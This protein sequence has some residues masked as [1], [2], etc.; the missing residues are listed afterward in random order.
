MS[1]IT[2]HFLMFRFVYHFLFKWTMYLLSSRF[3]KVLYQLEYEYSSMKNETNKFLILMG[4]VDLL[5]SWNKDER[6]CIKAT[7]MLT[8]K[9]H[10]YVGI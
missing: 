3:K 6:M 4:H 9:I 7:R 8:K 1:F 10:R 2:Y 5:S